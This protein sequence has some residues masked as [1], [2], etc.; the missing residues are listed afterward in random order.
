MMKHFIITID[1]EGDN[2]WEYR[3]G[4]VITTE[5]SQYIPRF[6]ELFER[7]GFIPTYLTNYEMAQDER[8][9]AYGKQ[10]AKEGKC[11]IGMHI[12]AWNSPPDYPLEDKYGGNPYIT[13]YPVDIMQSKVAYIRQILEDRFEVDITSNRSGRWATND[14]Y[15]RILA[16]EGVTVDCSVTPQLDLSGIPGRSSNTGNDYRACP[17]GPYILREGLIEVPM[18]TRK[19]RRCRNGSFKH[20]I[21]TLIVGDDMWLRPLRGKLDELTALTETAEK[22]NCGYL[23][24]MLHSSELMPG[25]SPYFKDK[26]SVDRMYSVLDAYFAYLT[27][28]GYKG[29]SL[30]GYADLIRGSLTG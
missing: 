13:E 27:D 24:F 5:N 22:D 3:H 18:T 1:T 14:D 23:E 11:E 6:Q 9:V 10:K 16:E 25:G 17:V 21:K 2:L 26:E 12:H 8:W 19:V 15:F 29:I 28:K 20:R 7:Y 4:S 30:T